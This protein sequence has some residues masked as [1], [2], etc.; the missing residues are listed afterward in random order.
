ERSIEM[1]V[2]ILGILKTGGAYLPID[3]GNPAERIEYILKDSG[4]QLLLTGGVGC[5]ESES[6]NIATPGLTL[7]NRQ[8]PSPAGIMCA[9]LP[10]GFSFAGAATPAYII[11]TSGTTGQP[12]G[13]MVEHRP[14]VNYICW[15]AGRYVGNEKV[16]FPLFTSISFDLTVTSIFVPLVTGNA[17]IVY[18]ESGKD[19]RLPIEEII[20]EDRVEAVK[21]TPS[22]L[23][24][25]R[26][27]KIKGGC[28]IKRFI[29]GGE[30]FKNAL[31]VE[32][33]RN[34]P[35]A[36]IYNEYGPTETTVG[37]MI[38]RSDP[39][40]DRGISVPIGLP[41]A[42]TRVYLLDTLKQ[43]VPPGVVGEIYIGG[44]GVAAGYLNRPGLTREKFGPDL[45]DY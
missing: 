27:I 7:A 17:V 19:Y 42:N 5:E 39:I 4:A 41:I 13:V 45:W 26:D 29:V 34:F 3:R 31:A 6:I 30:D 24:L 20:K 44:A 14:L 1:M 23:Q 35:A 40:K 10:D 25:I 32:I 12:K 2:G 36:E 28:H 16:N 9:A 22:H 11:Y 8:P 18:A 21:L 43:L 33:S 38:Y 37:C 15:A